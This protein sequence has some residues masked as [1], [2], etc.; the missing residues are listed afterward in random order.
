MANSSGA[1]TRVTVKT[2]TMRE[3]MF[4]SGG[5]CAMTDC[6]LPLTSPTGGWIG[7]V[8]HIVAAEQDGPRGNSPLTPK[9]RAEFSNLMLMCA[10]HGRDVDAPDTGEAN[11]P[12]ELLTVMKQ[13][14]EA[15]VNEAITAAI[16]QD[17][18][19]VKTATGAIDTE[20][21]PAKSATTAEGLLESLGWDSEPADDISNFVDLLNS[22]GDELQRF[23][24]LALDTLSQLLHIWVQDCPVD[25]KVGLTLGDPSDRGPYIPKYNVDNRI[26]NASVFRAGLRELDA[27]GVVEVIR[28]DEAGTVEYCFRDKWRLKMGKERY[29]FNFWIAT[30][31]FLHESF[32]VPIQDWLRGLDFEIYDRLA[33]PAA[34][35]SWR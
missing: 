32:G 20:L 13:R 8:A 34:K 30:A 3:L 29:D 11:Y 31:Y 25:P 9:E 21:R 17:Q 19:G 6:R 33:P 5:R 10:T 26:R 18:S 24:Q 2:Q 14:H 4:A 7:T 27:R 22:V 28:D 15:K 16:E 23:S 35:V 12:V 1:K